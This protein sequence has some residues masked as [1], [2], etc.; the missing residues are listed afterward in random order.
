MRKTLVGLFAASLLLAANESMALTMYGGVGR[1]SAVNPGALLI[2]NQNTGEGTLIGN[3]ITPPGGLTGIA[4]DST[5]ALYGSTIFGSGTTS[6]LVQIDPDTGSLLS[7]IGNITVDGVPISIGDL[8]FQP[9][10][11][12]LYGI[13]SN[14]DDQ[15]RAD[16]TQR[17][18]ELYTIDMATGAATLVGDTDGGAAGGLAF[19]PDGTLYQI[20]WSE[21]T[22]QAFLSL[23]TVNPVNASRIN[24]VAVGRFFDGLGIRPSDGALFAT[25]GGDRRS[26][27]LGIYIIN[28]TDGSSSFVGNNDAG[29]TS[30]LDFR[31]PEPALIDLD[32]DVFEVA[33]RSYREQEMS[34]KEYLT[35][36]IELPDWVNTAD[37][38]D[39]PVSLYINGTILTTAESSEIFGHLLVVR[40]QLTPDIV[41]AILGVEVTYVE[42]DEEHNRI[43]V[44]ATIPLARP[45]DLIELTV[46]GGNFSGT[47][48]VQVM[49]PSDHAPVAVAGEDQTVECASPAGAV[50]W[51]DAS[52]S[53]D[54]DGDPLT[55][56]W[57]GSFGTATGP[58]RTITLPLGIH[59][60]TLTVDDGRGETDLDVVT[61]TV[62]DT[63]P[64]LVNAAL[65][66]YGEME[67]DEGR[68]R[69]EFSCSDACDAS[70]TITSATLNG[71]PEGNGQW[72]ELELDDEREFGFDHGI[73][74]LEAPDFT[75]AVTCRDTAG[76]EATATAKPR[77]AV[78]NG[79]AGDH[80][81]RD[82]HKDKH[83]HKDKHKHRDKHEHKDKHEHR[84][85][86]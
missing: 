66:P 45:T 33:V 15:L 59:R 31:P 38:V 44:E 53:T 20:A 69:V 3:P 74:E 54:P 10:T 25:E 12:V 2:V 71:I 65:V 28:P 78:D 56:T 85:D 22:A 79:D 21:N 5:G 48:V 77:F 42:V 37:I 84:T 47:D 27:E 57:T 61:V 67:D 9:D 52:G 50:V 35:A 55:F 23:N 41:A 39:T 14:A 51:L 64:P 30:D 16:G 81:H 40:F 6:T 11:D 72:V 76:N 82:K 68:F 49:P 19:A 86:D 70:P 46:S 32:P 36:Y 18:G 75:L 13:R 7:T 60:I 80:K 62:E 58:T 8:A 63:V 34:G 4:F 1:G 73:L 83:E 29:F 17:G 24:T 26:V 43:V